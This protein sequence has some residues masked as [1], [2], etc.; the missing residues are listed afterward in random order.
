MDDSTTPKRS[1]PHFYNGVS[2]MANRFVIAAVV[3]VV[4]VV[5]V[6]VGVWAANNHPDGRNTSRIERRIAEIYG[7]PDT[8]SDDK[9]VGDILIER[10]YAVDPETGQ[11]YVGDVVKG[12]VKG[13]QNWTNEFGTTFYTF[14]LER[15][16]LQ[17]QRPALRSFVQKLA[18]PSLE[19]NAAYMGLV[20]Q[21]GPEDAMAVNF[22][23]TVPV[24][25]APFFVWN[26]KP[27]YETLLT[28]QIGALGAPQ[29]MPSRGYNFLLST[30]DLWP[31][32]KTAFNVNKAIWVSEQILVD[33]TS[34][35]HRLA[36]YQRLSGS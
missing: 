11:R 29:V 20:I 16:S 26:R 36:F 18:P 15:Q 22:D 12:R 14:V 25:R 9:V 27:M 30:T 35:E 7:R 23:G 19:E 2:L 28:Q 17:N 5:L 34:P 8:G 24:G 13:I 33:A 3:L 21:P 1:R 32:F 31:Y 4:A 6:P 10:F